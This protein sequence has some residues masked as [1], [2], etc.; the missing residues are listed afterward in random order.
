VDGGYPAPDMEFELDVGFIILL[1]RSY[2]HNSEV[3]R[4]KTIKI[5]LKIGECMVFLKCIAMV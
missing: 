2:M 5:R 4:T 1:S 3:Y